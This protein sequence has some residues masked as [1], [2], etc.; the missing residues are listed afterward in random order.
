MENNLTSK[1]LLEIFRN[2]KTYENAMNYIIKFIDYQKDISKV[3]AKPIPSLPEYVRFENIQHN[4][5]DLK[6]I[7]I[8]ITKHTLEVCKLDFISNIGT[9]IPSNKQIV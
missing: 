8:G 2:D 9:I 7:P 3:V 4:I 6:N 1:E 5:T